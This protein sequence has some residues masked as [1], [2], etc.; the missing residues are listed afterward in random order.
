MSIEHAMAAYYAERACEYER[1]YEKP[2]RQ[3]DLQRLDR[4]VER[5][6]A[7]TEVFEVACG[8]GYWTQV[9]ARS[10][11]FVLA[12]DLN[13]EV[14]NIARAKPL[15]AQKVAFLRADAYALP[16][17]THR[18]N[19]GLAAFWWSHIPKSRIRTFLNG[20]HR[21]LS[22]GARVMFIDNV[23]VEGSS[24]PMSRTDLEGNTYQLR[25]LGAAS[26][27]EVLKNFPTEPELRAALEGMALAVQVDFLP[28]YW[29]ATYLLKEK[30]VS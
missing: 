29:T 21:V 14:L 10:A 20:F 13:E 1:I 28:Y 30:E 17:A 18:F 4:I 15:D 7:G 25:Q 22:P 6:F 16:S 24:T 8:T 27:H 26:T 12:T 11:G 23:Y 5:T 2:E 19:A 9:L 3:A